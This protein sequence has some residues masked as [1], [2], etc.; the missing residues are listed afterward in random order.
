MI[1]NAIINKPMMA[2]L[3]C[4]TSALLS[5]EKDIVKPL[6][7]WHGK[8]PGRSSNSY[9]STERRLLDL[10]E[11]AIS[12]NTIYSTWPPVLS[13]LPPIDSGRRGL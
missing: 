1:I 3:P 7:V 12:I 4:K 8:I 6:F 11:S 2:S 13:A 9:R 5:F 10:T